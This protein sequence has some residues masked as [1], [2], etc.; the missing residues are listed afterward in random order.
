MIVDRRDRG[1]IGLAVAAGLTSCLTEVPC[2]S[3][4]KPDVR[5]AATSVDA[6]DGALARSRRT[7]ARRPGLPSSLASLRATTGDRLGE[8]LADVDT[9]S[10]S[11]SR[12]LSF[13]RAMRPRVAAHR[14]LADRPD[15][16]T[17]V[18]HGRRR[19]VRVQV[20][21][22]KRLPFGVAA[23]PRGSAPPGISAIDRRWHGLPL[24]RHHRHRAARGVRHVR[25]AAPSGP[26]ATQRGSRPTATSDRTRD[27]LALRRS[28]TRTALDLP[29]GGGRC[30]CS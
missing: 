7:T 27:V 12:S 26:R 23:Q 13:V 4:A 8:E 21:T 15:A 16:T 3:A 10:S 24:Q 2:G 11:S 1:R 30:S 29:A 25:L 9:V 6:R 18:D 28:L 19:P 22:K 17:G 14:D 5:P 20:A